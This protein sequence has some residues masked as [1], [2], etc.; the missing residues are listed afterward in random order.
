MR[1]LLLAQLNSYEYSRQELYIHIN[2]VIR[3]VF[4]ILWLDRT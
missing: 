3:N 4:L 1:S 2:T